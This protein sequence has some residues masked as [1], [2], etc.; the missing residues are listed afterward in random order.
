M[1]LL[2]PTP[3][4]LA[5]AFLLL[6]APPSP[7]AELFLDFST[8]KPGPPPPE[9]RISLTGSGPLPDWRVLQVAAAPTL[10]TLIP[11]SPTPVSE[12]VLA[13]VSEDT[14]DE[15]FPLLI[16][17]KESFSDFT[18]TL[19][20]RTVAGRSERMAGLAF[21]VVDEKNYYVV[22]ASSLGNTFRFYKFVDGIR[23]DPIGPEIRLPSG[24]WN[25]LEVS[26]RGNEIRCRLNDRDAIPTLTDTS[27]TQGKLALWTKS[28]SVSHFGS[29][30]V[31]YE[32]LKTLPQRLVD[33]ALEKYP[34][35]L[36][37]TVFAE[38]SGQ[39]KA[40][41]SSDPGELGS[42]ASPEEIRTLREGT[43]L[44]GNSK[45]SASAVFP[46]RDRNGDPMFAVRL[47]MRTFAGQ[48][49]NNV[50]ARARPIIEHLETLVGA[51]DVMRK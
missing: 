20:F 26:C 2:A 10:P 36:G 30:R 51:A 24:E 37:I 11:S 42:A 13:Q 45:K 15:R 12:T 14:T 6:T 40:L 18:A 47:R 28:D 32:A 25:T 17:D 8:L 23:S 4:L 50:A 27:F 3:A 48:T 39:V 29:L 19:K 35:L 44:A 43:V 22:R 31:V 33:S 34:R 46:I 16:Y 41:A 5:L 1:P 38:E 49:D 7:A 21:R 9:F